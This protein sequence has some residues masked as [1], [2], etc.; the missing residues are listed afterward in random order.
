MGM[1]SQFIPSYLEV[2]WEQLRI[3]FIPTRT[4]GQS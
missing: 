2:E 4:A 3:G 1:D